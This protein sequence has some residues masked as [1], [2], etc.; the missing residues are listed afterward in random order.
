[1]GLVRQFLDVMMAWVQ[2]DGDFT[3]R[4]LVTSRIKQSCMMVPTLFAMYFAAVRE[5]AL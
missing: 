4:Y 3:D 1:M 2:R 5:D